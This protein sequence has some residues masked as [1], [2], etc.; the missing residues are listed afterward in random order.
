MFQRDLKEIV[1]IF[2]TFFKHFKWESHVLT[3]MLS[4]ITHKKKFCHVKVLIRFT[5][6]HFNN[7]IKDNIKNKTLKLRQNTTYLVL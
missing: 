3:K 7:S 5:I 1:S 6:N 2:D 4:V